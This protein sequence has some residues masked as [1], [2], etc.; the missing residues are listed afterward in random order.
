[1]WLGQIGLIVAYICLSSI[2]AWVLIQHSSR[3]V[4]K[5]ILVAS[6]VWYGLGL[7]YST[8]SFMGWPVSQTVPTG[9]R[10]LAIRIQ[11]PNPKVN[12]PGAIYLWLS[13]NPVKKDFTLADVLDPRKVF[14][15][16]GE[17]EPRA[18]KLLYSRKFHKSIIRASRKKSK[19]PGGFIVTG[20]KKRKVTGKRRSERQREPDDQIEFKVI[21][22]IT[23]MRK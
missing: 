14:F 10:V 11:E 3:V 1:M 8:F 15:Y 17:K 2:L 7:Y 16:Y 13:T 20:K 22:P 21:N 4:I 9:S 19:T 18:Y 23:Q 12:S 6:V 5:A